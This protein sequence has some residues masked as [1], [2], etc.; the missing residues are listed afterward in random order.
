MNKTYIK[1]DS[2]AMSIEDDVLK[3]NVAPRLRYSS[4][5][6]GNRAKEG[7]TVTRSK[8][9][10]KHGKEKAEV[11]NKSRFLSHGKSWLVRDFAPS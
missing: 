8:R 7:M 1:D 5:D 6:A 4:H 9:G 3:P 11:R 10:I 2:G